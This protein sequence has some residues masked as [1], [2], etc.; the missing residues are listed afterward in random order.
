MFQ[1][2][3]VTTHGVTTPNGEKIKETHVHSESKTFEK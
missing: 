3:S 1:Y 2:S